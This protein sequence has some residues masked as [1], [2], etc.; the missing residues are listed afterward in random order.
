LKLY[1]ALIPLL[2]ACNNQG[3]P[4][5]TN[6]S[7]PPAVSQEKVSASPAP[8]PCVYDVQND[9]IEFHGI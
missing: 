1:C 3:T 5:P 4:S 2:A 7:V 8:K 9:L 6:N